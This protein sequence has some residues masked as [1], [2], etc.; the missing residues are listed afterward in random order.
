[1]KNKS[2]NVSE[3]P[4]GECG[5]SG[6]NSKLMDFYEWWNLITH[7]NKPSDSDNNTA[8]LLKND[9]FKFLCLNASDKI[10]ELSKLEKFTMYL[11]KCIKH[12]DKNNLS[13]IAMKTYIAYGSTQ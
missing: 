1:M 12:Q 13:T 3:L 5:T 9:R 6:L 10:T 8:M 2:S 11:K 4:E 7:L